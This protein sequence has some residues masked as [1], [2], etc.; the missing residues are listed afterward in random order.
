MSDSWNIPGTYYHLTVDFDINECRIVL[1]GK[2]YSPY[3][4]F[5]EWTR[6]TD[7]LVYGSNIA[8]RNVS[9]WREDGEI[10]IVDPR[11]GD[12]SEYRIPAKHAPAMAAAVM[13]MIVATNVA[14]KKMKK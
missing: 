7:A 8:E 13:G 3:G 14:L 4:S 11:D 1:S 9:M 2:R 5:D 6:I 10:V 12:G